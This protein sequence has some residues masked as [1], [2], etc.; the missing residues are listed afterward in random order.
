M[1]TIAALPLHPPGAKH[2]SVADSRRLYRID[3]WGQG[4]FGISDEGNLQLHC[5]GQ[6]LDVYRLIQ[7]LRRQGHDLP[8]L[9]RC[10]D[11]LRAQLTTL[12]QC[13]RQAMQR[14]HYTGHYTLIYPIKVNQ[15]RTVVEAIATHP[16]ATGLEAGSKSELLA[17]LALARPGSSV[18]CNGHKDPE[19]I[20]LALIGCTMHLNVYL[21]ID[22]PA[23]CRR[24][25]QCVRD[26][27]I[28]PMLGI[29]IKLRSGAESKRQKSGSKRCKF[30]LRSSQIVHAIDRL[31]EANLL[32]KLQLMHFHIGSQVSALEDFEAALSEAARYYT[33]LRKLGA[34]L[35][36]VDVGGGL[37]VDYEGKPS[38]RPCAI[39]YTLQDYADCIVRAFREVGQPDIISESGRAITAHHALL[40]SNVVEVEDVMESTPK[41]IGKNRQ[42][43]GYKTKGT[44]LF[45]ELLARA[46]KAGAADAARIHREAEYQ[47]A[48]TQRMFIRGE[49][50]L[51][52][53]GEAE[54][55]YYKICQ[56]L[57]PKLAESPARRDIQGQLAATY[58]C[59]FSLFRSLPD[60]WAIAQIFPIMPIHRLQE[61]PDRQ[62]ILH[63]LSCDSDG[64]VRQYVTQSG[65]STSLPVPASS[66]AGK[67]TLL[68]LF[69]LGAYQ[70]VLGD[71]HN[72]FGTTTTVN[73][74]VNRQGETC[75]EHCHAGDRIGA[76][77]QHIDMDVAQ[78]Q[79]SYRQRMATAKLPPS[80]RT[81]YLDEL[82]SGLGGQSY[83]NGQD[84]ET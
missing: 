35:K 21:V 20:R 15:Q 7:Q 55:Q 40:I 28:S 32:Q 17:V 57:Y 41:H 31:R 22:K 14:Y 64:R 49:L 51:P 75:I 33:E 37:G 65:P 84:G 38:K 77:L 44:G 9:I 10:T 72:L 30:G 82:L 3:A 80:L 61:P 59:N 18:I 39:N 11:I 83:L 12:H 71:I 1:G 50:D 2:W 25:I 81:R 24:I 58:V 6:A 73:V 66:P 13:F 5:D 42:R 16:Q 43:I 23:E 78:V 8:I 56:S 46:E 53:L 76:L 36:Q 19:Y 47:M 62:A 48:E 79:E 52:R 69:L 4:Y 26:M 74:R 45:Q 54:E 70:E 27:G 63:D 60:S 29:R 68:G 67:E 34:P